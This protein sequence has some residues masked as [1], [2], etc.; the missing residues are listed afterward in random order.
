MQL[1]HKQKI[2][3]FYTEPTTVSLNFRAIQSLKYLVY[4]DWT[5]PWSQRNH[6]FTQKCKEK[7]KLLIVVPR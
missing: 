3:H 4:R 2:L 6:K 1:V 5:H 7:N